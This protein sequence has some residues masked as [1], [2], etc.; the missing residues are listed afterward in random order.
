MRAGPAFSG[1]R[2]GEYL[3]RARGPLGI[4]AAETK[5]AA[6]FAIDQHALAIDADDAIGQV[7]M[8]D[9]EG[10]IA[11]HMDVVEQAR[12]EVQPP[13]LVVHPGGDGV[14][15]VRVDA[16]LPPVQEARRRFRRRDAENP[17]VEGARLQDVQLPLNAIRSGE[18]RRPGAGSGRSR[19]SSRRSKSGVKSP[20][21]RL[22][23]LMKT[24]LSIAATASGARA[25]T[26]ST[27]RSAAAGRVENENVRAAGRCSSDSRTI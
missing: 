23:C 7:P 20:S 4:V 25:G 14:P 17:D 27:R 21:T 10:G 3:V 8:P 24:T 19:S 9:V 26:G 5:E 18:R 22:S 16:V 1:V 15:A 12:Y 6:W 11:Q 2:R 13:L